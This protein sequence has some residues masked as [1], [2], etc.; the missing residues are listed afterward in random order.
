MTRRIPSEVTD[1][2]IRTAFERCPSGLIVVDGAGLI[3]VVNQEVERLFG[4]SRADLLGQ[5]VELLVP[6]LSA[7][8]HAKLREQY[9]QKPTARRMGAGR[10][11]FARHKD[12]REIPVEIGLS[13]ITTP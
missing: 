1:D 12:G 10:E 3:T 2:F 6:D 9:A 8:G 4:Y 13:P 5:S 7:G 11:L